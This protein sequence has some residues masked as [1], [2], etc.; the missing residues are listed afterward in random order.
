MEYVGAADYYFW[1]GVKDGVEGYVEVPEFFMSNETTKSC[2]EAYTWG[3]SLGRSI[4]HDE[5]ISLTTQPEPI[6]IS[7]EVKEEPKSTIQPKMVGN[8]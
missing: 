4:T 5:Y 6:K 3:A 1:Q 7:V 2:Q 8:C